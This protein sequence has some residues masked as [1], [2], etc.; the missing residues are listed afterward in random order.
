MSPLPSD[1][2]KTTKLILFRLLFL[3]DSVRACCRPTEAYSLRPWESHCMYSEM[4]RR[5]KKKKMRWGMKCERNEY[6]S[7]GMANVENKPNQ[8]ISVT[9]PPISISTFH[10]TRRN[11][12]SIL[13]KA[14]TGQRP[15][16]TT[17]AAAA[18]AVSRKTRTPCTPGRSFRNYPQKRAQ[19]PRAP[20][21]YSR[22]CP[23]MYEI[24]VCN[25]LISTL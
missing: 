14:T 17:H 7:P 2:S 25:L 19:T 5:K 13:W 10:N 22:R 21:P 9:Y 23:S 1:G 11:A 16:A 15:R 20:V 6:A 3:F 24:T 8:N 18:A 4:V 12:H